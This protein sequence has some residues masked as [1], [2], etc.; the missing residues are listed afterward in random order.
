MEDLKDI[1]GTFIVT[2]GF[3]LI[4]HFR[5]LRVKQYCYVFLRDYKKTVIHS[6]ACKLKKEGYRF[7]TKGVR[8]GKLPI[9]KIKVTRIQ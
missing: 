1:E 2:K 9:E 6:T 3:T 5:A 4:D 7:E 8:R